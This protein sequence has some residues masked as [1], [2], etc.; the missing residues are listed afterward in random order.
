M[1]KII[2]T[3]GPSTESLEKIIELIEAGV[4]VFRINFSHGSFE[5]YD[6]LVENIREA[7]KQT[8]V[9]VAILGDLS[10]PKIRFGKV[11]PNGINLQKGDEIRFVKKQVIGGSP[12]N[13]HVFSTTYPQFINEVKPDEKILID[14]GN[15]EL[16]CIEKTG[17]GK[18]M[19]MVCKVVVGNLLT[20]AKGINLP[21]SELSLPSLTEK[22][23]TCVEYAVR[24]K[25]FD[26]LALSFVRS[27]KD[28][29]VLKKRLTELRVR[30]EGLALTGGDL[31]FSTSF[32]DDYIPIISKIE[33]PQAIENLEEILEESDGVMVARGDLGVEMDLAEVA[34]L[35]KKIISMCR[36]KMKPVIVATQMLQSMINEPVPTRAEVSDVA[37]A[38]IDGADAVMLSGETAV[39]KYPVETV[40]MMN[41]VGS[42]THEFIKEEIATRGKFVP[43]EGLLKRKAAMARGVA[44]MAK[45]MN[46]KFIVT[47]TH[48]GG[49]TVFLS[50]QKLQIPII[51]CGENIKRL[52]QMSLLYSITPHYLKQPKSGSK[53][54]GCINTM[55]I[56][57]GWA[58]E[59]DPII[60]VASS[61]ISKRGITNRV[62][63][64][65]VG[66]S[67]GE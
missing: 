43:Y 41:R 67:V 2:A 25:E 3:L 42:K 50:Q 44:M 32:D 46:V 17:S 28:I 22:D 26:F 14:D 48:S 11:I 23:F 45:D 56:E 12:G 55:L 53:F 1:T 63:L 61:P 19:G 18:E 29:K 60:V 57:K 5:E 51:A 62:V 52:Q 8:A 36:H 35:Q 59:G 16:K 66:E 6:M 7:E 20:S 27:A 33:K 49:S 24:K 9:Y 64:H 4:R 38:I 31:G 15:I 30:P 40:K 39:G 21:D 54:I 34:I 47:W 65:Y 10:G 58:K 37:N 13:E